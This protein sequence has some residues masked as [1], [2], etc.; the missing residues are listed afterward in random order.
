MDLWTADFA[1]ITGD[2]LPK[3]ACLG[4]NLILKSSLSGK[5]EI[6]TSYPQT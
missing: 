3:L 6:Y 1:P 4:V 5:R 2:S